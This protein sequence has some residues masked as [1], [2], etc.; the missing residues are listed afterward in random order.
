[1]MIKHALFIGCLALLTACSNMQI[2]VDN[3]TLQPCPS[4]PNC[5][6]SLAT[7][8][9]AIIALP[10]NLASLSKL[11][12]IIIS[13]EG[14]ALVT[15]TQSYLHATCE[16]KIFGFID[17]LEF[18][19]TPQAIHIRAAART[20]FSDLGVNRERIESIRKKLASKQ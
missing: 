17:D 1:M 14:C 18:V 11:E 3:E 20:G 12:S 6:N 4:K 15:I 2:S 19:Q 5:V 8:S 16:S 10:T 13:L 9:H 7:D